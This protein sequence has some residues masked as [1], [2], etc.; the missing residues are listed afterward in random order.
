MTRQGALWILTL[1]LLALGAA[2]PRDVEELLRRGEAAFARREFAAAL[3]CYERAEELAPDPGLVAFNKAAV[4]YRLGRFREAEQCYRRCLDDAAV[5]GPR[6]ARALYD[7]GTSLVHVADGKDAQALELAVRCLR[8]CR[9]AADPELAAQ[10]AYNLELARLLWARA[11]AS[12]N[13]AAPPPKDGAEPQQGKS[14]D[15]QPGEPSEGEKGS[16]MSKG[17][18][19]SPDAAKDQKKAVATQ[20]QI[21]G[22][23][24]LRPLPDDEELQPL[25]PRDMAAHLE[26]VARRV[27]RE[28]RDQRLVLPR[29]FPG[30]KDW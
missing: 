10:A 28:Q 24:N 13:D 2:S 30:V 17:Q 11:K 4:L 26:R 14:D 1:T 3:A 25:D 22:K 18:P 8:Q 9:R 23:G 27:A 7:L 12:P 16:P 21:A 5:P 19:L 20:E 15:R 6:R 29:T